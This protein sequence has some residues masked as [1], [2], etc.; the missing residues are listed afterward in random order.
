MRKPK[1]PIETIHINR[2]SGFTHFY[3]DDCESKRG[4]YCQD[5]YTRGKCTATLCPWYVATYTTPD[6]PPC[7]HKYTVV[8]EW[9]CSPREE[10]Y[11]NRDGGTSTKE[12]PTKRATKIMCE[13]CQDIKEVKQ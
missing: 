2:G 3:G 6:K 7:P 10:Y 8:V 11:R 1:P 9:D 5:G 12:T 13:L 4:M